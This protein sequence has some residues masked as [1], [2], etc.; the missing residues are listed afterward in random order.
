MFA[1]VRIAIAGILLL[2]GFSKL[3]RPSEFK[4]VL[5]NLSLLPPYVNAFVAISLPLVELALGLLLCLSASRALFF[6]ATG[7]FAAFAFILAIAL[8]RGRSGSC[9]CWGTPGRLT[10]HHPIRT[11]CLASLALSAAVDSFRPF[12]ITVAIA[13]I[14]SVWSVRGVRDARVSA[15]QV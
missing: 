4:R 14:S 7:L 11:L 12:V 9:G 15:P 5:K 3:R 6:A 8:L 2:A 10:W 13:L 1:F